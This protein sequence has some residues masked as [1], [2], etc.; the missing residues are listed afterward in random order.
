MMMANKII[1]DDPYGLAG[2]R[3]LVVGLGMTGLSGK[4]VV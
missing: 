3:A 1:A 4:S 2:K